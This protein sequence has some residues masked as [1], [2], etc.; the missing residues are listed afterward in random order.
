MGWIQK[1]FGGGDKSAPAV[2]IETGTSHPEQA[3]CVKLAG[4][5]IIDLRPLP[6]DP[7][8][9]IVAIGD[10]AKKIE[11]APEPIQVWVVGTA[12]LEA[13]SDHLSELVDALFAATKRVEPKMIVEKDAP[14]GAVYIMR[15][16][17]FEVFLPGLKLTTTDGGQIDVLAQ[18]A[19]IKNAPRIRA[20]A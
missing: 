3:L 6:A 2:I 20:N 9:A 19:K 14:Q 7:Q 5:Y 8:R 17:G 16:L 4:A 10:I 1:L 12:L 11:A 15:S 13:C 18:L